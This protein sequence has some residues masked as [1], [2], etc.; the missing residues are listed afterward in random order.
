MVNAARSASAYSVK[1]ITLTHAARLARLCFGS[2]HG[3]MQM[4]DIHHIQLESS[5]GR[6]EQPID[7]PPPAEHPEEKPTDSEEE[8]QERETAKAFERAIAGLSAG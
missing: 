7:D 6:G 1:R 3:G 5:G 8:L 4:P 2:F